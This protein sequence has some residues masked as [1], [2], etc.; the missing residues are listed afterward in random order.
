MNKTHLMQI[1]SQIKNEKHCFRTWIFYIKE[2]YGEDLE[3]KKYD[4]LNHCTEW[5]VKR[6]K[7]RD[8]IL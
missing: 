7:H 6:I 4:D 3:N 5:F 1:H 8:E 2:Y